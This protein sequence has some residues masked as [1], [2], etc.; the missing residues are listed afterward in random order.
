MRPK[1]FYWDIVVFY[2][3]DIFPILWP[4]I[5][6]YCNSPGWRM[7]GHRETPSHFH[8]QKVRY[9]NMPIMRISQGRSM[10]LHVHSVAYFVVGK[11]TTQPFLGISWVI[12][13]DTDRTAKT[14]S[15][16]LITKS[17]LALN[18][19]TLKWFLCYWFCEDNSMVT[20]GILSQRAINVLIFTIKLLNAEFETSKY[21][22]IHRFIRYNTRTNSYTDTIGCFAREMPAHTGSNKKMMWRQ[23]IKRLAIFLNS[24]SHCMSCKTRLWQWD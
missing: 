18:V 21:S 6:G 23:T 8:F 19:M 12:L 17:M 2:F 20:D 16:S 9:R 11:L 3:H 15:N 13:N 5:F 14:S 4:K 24:K 10:I 22:P 1:G 7:A